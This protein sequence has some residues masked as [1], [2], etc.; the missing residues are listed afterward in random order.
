MTRLILISGSGP[1]AGKSTFARKMGDEVWS[2]AGALR[3]ELQKL[4]PQYDWFN[5]SQEYKDNTK[6][7]EYGEYGDRKSVREVLVE[8]GQKK[9]A[10]NPYTWVSQLSARLLDESQLLA[11]SRVYCIDDVRKV[12]ELEY[13]RGRFINVTHFHLETAGVPLEPEFENDEL[14]ARADY[15]VQWKR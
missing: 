4:Y 14:K 6:V 13:L 9:C 12:C 1:G 10:D 7:A 15:V 8:Y 11:G 3:A 5:K 2:I